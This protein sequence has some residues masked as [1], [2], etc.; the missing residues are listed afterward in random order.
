MNLFRQAISQFGGTSA[1]K[2][3]KSDERQVRGSAPQ[4]A[5]DY[6]KSSLNRQFFTLLSDLESKLLQNCA[7]D[8]MNQ[9]VMMYQQCIEHYDGKK[10]DIKYYFVEK[11][12]NLVSDVQ[13]LKKLK[14]SIDELQTQIRP[15]VNVQQMPNDDKFVERKKREKQ[16]KS[17]IS[18]QVKSEYDINTPLMG[19]LVTQYH[20]IADKQKNMVNVDLEVQTRNIEARLR[21]RNQIHLKLMGMDDQFIFLYIQ[22]LKLLPYEM[23]MGKLRQNAEL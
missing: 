18:H 3:G 21:R 1:N 14:Q 8:I 11:I 12:Q 13:R 10:D 23:I 20:D 22:F 9:L 15:T 17:Q 4:S 7:G 2:R 16:V 6:F 5:Q 19:D